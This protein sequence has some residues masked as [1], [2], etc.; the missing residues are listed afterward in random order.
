MIKF[1]LAI[2]EWYLKVL[3]LIILRV[4]LKINQINDKIYIVLF[5]F[6]IFSVWAENNYFESNFK[7]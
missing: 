7:K 5:Y 2:F 4:Y 1:I 3:I 6:V